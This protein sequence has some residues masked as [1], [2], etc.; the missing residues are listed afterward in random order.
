M[1][2]ALIEKVKVGDEHA[3]R[4]LV[5]MYRNIVFHSVYAV[6]QNQKDAEDATQEVFF[7][8]YL[9][10]SKYENQGFKT[11]I[12]RIAVNHAI[13]MKRKAYR[14]RETASD[15]FQLDSEE[16]TFAASRVESVDDQVVK[17]EMKRLV[18]QRIHELPV[19]YRDVIYGF[20]IEDKTYEELAQEQN[21][22]RDTIATKLHRARLW[23][24]KHWRESDFL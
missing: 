6:L 12:L 19:N 18:R 16:T 14:K 23:I 8:I 17:K 3:F 11:W 22:K 21:V 5:E 10:L 20:Y 1:E 13:D 15:D 4:V 7:K 24:K 2:Q 9:S